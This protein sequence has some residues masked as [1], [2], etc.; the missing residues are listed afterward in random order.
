MNK[1]SHLL[2][3][4][5]YCMILNLILYSYFKHH[6]TQNLNYLNL[7]LLLYR[8]NFKINGGKEILEE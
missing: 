1:N 8:R 5:E 3:T 2:V 7:I 4:L 6:F